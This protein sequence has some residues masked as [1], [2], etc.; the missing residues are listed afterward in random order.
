VK[1]QNQI[2]KTLISA[3]M[4]LFFLLSFATKSLHFTHDH[5]A[6]DHHDEESCEI[7][8]ACHLELFHHHLEPH[9]GC[10]HDSHISEQSDECE[11]C[12]FFKEQRQDILTPAKELIDVDFKNIVQTFS[13]A[14]KGSSRNVH[15]YYLRGP[16]QV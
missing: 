3:S 11:L 14:E 12:Q 1:R 9:E 6:H 8:D 4:L 2:G 13:H 5:H 10:E 7:T 16:P 15:T